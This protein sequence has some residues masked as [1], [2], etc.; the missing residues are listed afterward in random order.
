MGGAQGP[1]TVGAGTAA[2]PAGPSREKSLSP[3]P[4]FLLAPPFAKIAGERPPTLSASSAGQDRGEAGW[5]AEGEQPAPSFNLEGEKPGPHSVC[6]FK[7]S[8]PSQSR[9]YLFSTFCWMLSHCED[10]KPTSSLQEGARGLVL[11][12][13]PMHRAASRSPPSSHPCPDHL[14]GSSDGQTERVAALGVCTWSFFSSFFRLP[15]WVSTFV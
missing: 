6:L 8:F 3:A 4:D 15:R 2:G 12:Q 5:V 7:V 11:E 9:A 1:P 14:G 13:K 10:D